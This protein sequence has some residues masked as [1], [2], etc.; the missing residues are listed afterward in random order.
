MIDVTNSFVQQQ[1]ST[2]LTHHG[3]KGMKWGVRKDEYVDNKKERLN[4]RLSL[5]E[6][7]PNYSDRQR[8]IDAKQKDE[9][10]VRRMN[11]RANSGQ[12]RRQ[13]LASENKR[14]LSAFKSTLGSTATGAVVGGLVGQASISMLVNATF[15]KKGEAFLTK[16]LGRNGALQFAQNVAYVASSPEGRRMVRKGGAMTGAL[17]GSTYGPQLGAKHYDHKE[18]KKAIDEKVKK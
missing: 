5:Y 13:A 17:L 7:N 6:K 15:S 11:R 3:V 18:V 12:N 16:N 4:A 14:K 1:M 2:E 10:F 9:A 8:K